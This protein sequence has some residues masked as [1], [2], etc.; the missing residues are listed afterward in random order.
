M[1]VIQDA[2][3][4]I[5]KAWNSGKPA[6]GIWRL[7]TYTVQTHCTDGTLLYNVVSGELLFLSAEEAESL[8][9]LPCAYSSW[10]DAL[11][12]KRFLVPESANDMETVQK[13]RTILRMVNR[14]TVIS[15][16][17][18]LP[19]MACNARCFYCYE[20]DMPHRTMTAETVQDT[21]GFIAAHHGDK[22]VGLGWFGG[23]PTVAAKQIEQICDGLKKRGI[24]YTS[25]M[26]SNGYLLTE[27]VVR[28]AKE[29]WKLKSIQ[30]TLD[31]TEEIYN[32]TKAYVGISGSPYQ[33]VLENIGHLLA[34]EIRVSIRLN[35]GLH[36]SEDLETLIRELAARFENKKYLGIYTHLLFEDCGYS[37]TRFENP[38]RELL[39]EK[40]KALDE[41][42]RSLGFYVPRTPLP[43]MKLYGCMADNDCS[44]L[45][46]PEG[47][48]GKCEHHVGD[49]FTGTVKDGVT[50][51]EIL[52][53]YRQT[54]S[55]PKCE[56]CFH[57]PA[58]IRLS[59]C[60]N[61]E[62]CTDDEIRKKQISVSDEM[63][64]HYSDFLE[65][66][67]TGG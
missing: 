54:V 34:A 56:G 64:R 16:Y 10:M 62:P 60:I 1:K 37:P 30:I 43:V 27:A 59:A 17:T 21:V 9:S 40:E 58:C 28:H 14:A 2:Q 66:P 15:G 24:E 11:I 65:K 19:T 25:S 20:S 47:N 29:D 4:N 36:N 23:E 32:R 67:D 38:E 42:I 49:L 57:Y 33:Q 7:L 31:G 26:I 46:T 22:P 53:E 12:E 51:P 52:K 39:K 55:Y 35:L 6:P 50:K 3:S 45:I 8:S 48:L 18:I 41:L 61:H 5:Q 44:V 63:M 13:L